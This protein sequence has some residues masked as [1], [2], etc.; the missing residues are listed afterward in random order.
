MQE[1]LFRRNLDSIIS[2]ANLVRCQGFAFWLVVVRNMLLFLFWRETSMGVFGLPNAESACAVPC[3][4]EALLRRS[5]PGA[6]PRSCGVES[7]HR[8]RALTRLCRHMRLRLVAGLSTANVIRQI[9]SGAVQGLHVLV[10]VLLKVLSVW[11][12][13]LVYCLRGPIVFGQYGNLISVLHDPA[14]LQ[15]QACAGRGASVAVS[16]PDFSASADSCP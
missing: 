4:A 10:G 5:P 7:S 8:G 1:Q 3:R 16:L 2:G 6:E 12:V 15:Q 13:V 11:M 14:V 9:P